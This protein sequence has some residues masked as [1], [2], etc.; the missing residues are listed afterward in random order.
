MIE[1]RTYRIVAVDDNEDTL[2]VLRFA[3]QDQ[4]EILTLSN[5]SDLYELIEIFEPDLLILDV[6][7][8]KVTGFQ[9]VK[10][11]Q[12]H[13]RTK[14]IPVVLL[15]AKNAPSDLKY[16]YNLGAS[17][18]LTKPFTPERLIKNVETQIKTHAISNAPK[19]MTLP[20][21]KLEL[22]M[23]PAFRKGFVQLSSNDMVSMLSDS[24]EKDLK[25]RFDRHHRAK[26]KKV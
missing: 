23:K 16:G 7:M 22:Q 10:M 2:E 13:S 3:L 15:S 14:N 18:Y 9:L 1:D 6:M 19:K 4:Y 26:P 12:R 25:K 8:P 5:P 24:K 17:L 11:L 21:V 20:Q